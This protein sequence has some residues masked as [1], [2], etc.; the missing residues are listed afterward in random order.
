MFVNTPDA[1]QEMLYR[2]L[3][4]SAVSVDTESN[5][6]Y[7]YTERVCLVQFSVPGQDYLVDPIQVEDLSSLG[8][9]FA[10]PEVEKIF[11]AAEYDVISLRRDY[12]FEFVNVFDTM[13]ASRIVGWPRYGLAVLLE[14]HFGVETNKR[15]QRTNWGQRPLTAAQMEYARLDTHFLVSLR[16]RLN[17]ELDAQDRLEEAR[18]A[19]DRVS[20]STWSKKEFDPDDFW[21]VKGAR[22]LDEQGRAILRELYV[23][24]DKRAQELDWPPFKVL[25]DA[26]LVDLSQHAPRSFAELGRIKGLPRRLP[27]QER[28][29]LLGVIEYGLRA[30]TPKARKRR[31]GGRPSEETVDRYEALRAWRRERAQPR[32]V[33][34]DVILSNHILHILAHE[35]PTSPEQLDVL[36]VLNGWERREYGREVVALLR[37]HGR[38]RSH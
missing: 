19:F 30:P 36:N 28:R 5:S 10:D 29:K 31:G 38:I 37:R 8:M 2:L 13:I 14:E 11:H 20:A 9:L 7:A 32:G 15:M 3:A 18:A 21:R 33:E 1:L 35:N 22:D 4:S 16:D 24:R 25:N 12:Q 17:A 6:L 26:V 27:S 23:Y 34:P